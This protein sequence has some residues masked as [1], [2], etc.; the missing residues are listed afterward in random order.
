M[1]NKINNFICI[2]AVHRDNALILKTN[3]FVNRTNPVV[4]KQSLG[5]VAYNIASKI[6]FFNQKVELISLNCIDDIKK[7]IK[8]RKIKFRAI[9]KSIEKRSYTTILDKKGNII[10]GLADMDVYEKKIQTLNLKFDPQKRIIFDL[11]LSSANIK[12]LINQF[13]KK[14]IISICGTSSHKVYKIKN[15]LHKIQ[16]L[17]L[18][19]QESFNLTQ[20]KNIRKS[21]K[22]LIRKNSKLT[23]LITNGKNRITGYHNGNIYYCYPPKIKIKNESGAGDAMSAVFIY[24]YTQS[25]SFKEL[26]L[27]SAVAGSL[28]ANGYKVLNKKTYIETINRIS[29]TL[30]ITSK[31]YNGQ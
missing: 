31:K 26:L 5:G 24:L 1:N 10:L 21:L 3:Y 28:H 15:L 22:Y 29:K 4:Q 11:N 2:G 23:I 25:I 19:K 30:K 27:K 18:N 16:I 7:E 12:K 13:Y 14:N 8:K 17:I 9:N 20:K 6:A